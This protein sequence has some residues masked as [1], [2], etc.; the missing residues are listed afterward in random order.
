MLVVKGNQA[1]SVKKLGDSLASL[2]KVSD[3]IVAEKEVPLVVDSIKKGIS[4]KD[5]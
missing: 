2:S 4:Y 3:P 1:K 5:S